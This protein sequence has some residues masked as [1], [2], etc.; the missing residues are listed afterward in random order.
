M[1]I[2]ERFERSRRQPKKEL[3][4]QAATLSGG[5]PGRPRTDLP[6]A[7]NA[8]RSPARAISLYASG[9]ASCSS[10]GEPRTRSGQRAAAT[11]PTDCR[12]GADESTPVPPERML[13]QR[14]MILVARRQRSFGRVHRCR[15]PE[16]RTSETRN[17]QKSMLRARQDIRARHSRATLRH[18]CAPFRH[19]RATLRH[20]CAPFR[21]SRATLRHSRVPFRHPASPS[22]IPASPSVIPAQAGIHSG[23]RTPKL[24]F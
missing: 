3:L 19:S 11:E 8:E 10:D 21:H 22:V 15:R 24:G 2:A 6:W 12:D 20:S 9:P 23:Q 18:S 13:G 4:H 7:V 14:E 1:S 16:R 5:E 17:I